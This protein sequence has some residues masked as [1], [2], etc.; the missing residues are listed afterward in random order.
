[1]WRTDYP[2]P[3]KADSSFYFNIASWYCAGFLWQGFGGEVAT[4]VTFERGGSELPSLDM[5]CVREPLVGQLASSQG[6]PT[7]AEMMSSGRRVETPRA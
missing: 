2:L 6:Q 5:A 1:M 3:F 4:G 7:S